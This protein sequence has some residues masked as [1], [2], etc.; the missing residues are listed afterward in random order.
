VHYQQQQQKSMGGDDLDDDVDTMWMKPVRGG[1]GG[2]GGGG[3]SSDDDDDDDDVTNDMR[4][5]SIENDVLTMNTSKRRITDDSKDMNTITDNDI[6]NDTA[7]SNTGSSTGSSKKG[8]N[9][10]LKSSL[11]D[12]TPRNQMSLSSP[13][14]VLLQLGRTVHEESSME[15][16]KYLTTAIR[17]Y[18]LLSSADTVRVSSVPSPVT[19]TTT[20]TN[21]KGNENNDSS[22][23]VD[24]DTNTNKNVEGDT[25]VTIAPQHCLDITSVITGSTRKNDNNNNNTNSATHHTVVGHWPLCIRQVVSMKTLRE[26]KHYGSPCIV[27]EPTDLRLTSCYC[28][29]FL[30]EITF[31]PFGLKKLSSIL[32]KV[33][34]CV[35]ARRAVSVLKEEMASFKVRTGKF[36]PKNGSILEQQQQLASSIFPIVIGTPHRLRQLSLLPTGA[37]NHDH[38][39]T[40]STTGNTKNNNG[41]RPLNWD[42]TQLVII[43]N[44]QIPHKQY[45]VCTLPDTASDCMNLLKEQV[46]PQLSSTTT[47]PTTAKDHRPNE[48]PRSSKNRKNA[49]RCQILF[50]N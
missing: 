36:F 6:M 3:G 34:I 47:A 48:P 50:L 13:T 14:Q 22:N 33:I 46:Y 38:Q 18:T 2:A 21:P 10:K 15:Q 43:D 45:T 42:Y 5:D 29:F 27:S 39:S 26:W 20:T 23:D 44:Y 17:H 12:N 16:A 9:K 35:S 31:S 30:L 7:L 49:R 32:F 1:H 19:T 37:T 40:L 28:R 25:I 41:T 24:V 4:H 8:K 11:S